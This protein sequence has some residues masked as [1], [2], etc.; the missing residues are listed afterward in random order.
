MAIRT[1]VNRARRLGSPIRRDSRGVGAAAHGRD[2]ADVLACE[3]LAELAG[4]LLSGREVLAVINPERASVDMFDMYFTQPILLRSLQRTRQ[5]AQPALQACLREK[6]PDVARPTTAVRCQRD[7][8]A[9]A[10]RISPLDEVSGKVAGQLALRRGVGV[11]RECAGLGVGH[12]VP[13]H[14]CRCADMEMRGC[15]VPLMLLYHNKQKNT[16]ESRLA[17]A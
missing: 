13:F 14:G 12:S 10:E 7:A 2:D 15:I 1:G 9:V 4:K 6:N 3:V 5:E 17:D 11:R 16:I 8:T